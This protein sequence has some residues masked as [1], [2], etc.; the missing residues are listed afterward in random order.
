MI[1][2]WISGRRRKKLL[3][4]PV[5][6]KWSSWIADNVWHW[7]VLTPAM[8]QRLSGLTQIFVNEKVFEGCDGLVVTEEMKVTIAAAACLLLVGFGDTYCFDQAKTLLVYP[9]PMVQ[10][11]LRKA[12]GVVDPQ[13]WVSG[14]A[15]QRGPILLSWQDVLND[16]RD[17]QSVNNV[18]V[19][20]FA[21]YVDGI[22]GDMEG[23][24]P[25]PT[26]ELRRE[27]HQLAKQE[28]EA[29]RQAI[30]RGHATVLDPYGASNLTELFAVATEA[31]FCDGL[32]LQIHHPR[33]Y[34]MLALLYRVESCGWF[35]HDS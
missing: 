18:V 32:N 5:D 31:F 35:R 21:H 30:S 16:C 8:R 23:V 15:A 34:A 20:E 28:L 17:E 11:N 14:M 22:D 24:P 3:V 1:F 25:L 33:I 4:K 19:H 6:E 9:R 7:H 12:D 10:R 26:E 27:W 13:T 2:D 29:L